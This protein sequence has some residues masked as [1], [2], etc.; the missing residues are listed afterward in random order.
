MKDIERTILKLY[1]FG[2]YE[3]FLLTYTTEISGNDTSRRK[4][5]DLSVR[6]DI[7]ASEI[8]FYKTIKIQRKNFSA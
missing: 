1:V 4:I 6:L 7:I 2:N 8:E 3:Y 5:Q